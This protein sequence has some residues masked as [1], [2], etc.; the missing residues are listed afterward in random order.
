MILIILMAMNIEVSVDGSGVGLV[1]RLMS[2]KPVLG[3]VSCVVYRPLVVI[4]AQANRPQDMQA[5][6]KL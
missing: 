4:H 1:R 6:C 5:A 2:V 3:R